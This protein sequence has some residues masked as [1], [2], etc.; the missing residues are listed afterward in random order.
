MA[1]FKNLGFPSPKTNTDIFEN[2]ADPNEASCLIRIY[3]ACHS[4]DF[5]RNPCLQ[6]IVSKF[7]DGRV[8]VRNAGVKGLE[9]SI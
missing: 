3:T 5:D 8:D 4:V 6:Q 2:S 9:C 7:G 1:L